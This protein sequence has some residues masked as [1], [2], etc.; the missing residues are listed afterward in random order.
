MIIQ[1]Q[2]RFD[3]LE[4]LR[5]LAAW[6]VVLFH[7]PK[8]NAILDVGIINNSYLM[9]DFFFVLSGFVIFYSYGTKITAKEDLFR[10]QF[11]RFARLYPVHILF[12]L[13]FL[14]FE[15]A[16]QFVQT[17]WGIESVN[18]SPFRENNF[19]AFFQQVFLVHALGPTGNSTSF[20]SPAWSI[21]TEFYTYL[22]FGW[23]LIFIKA[24]RALFFVAVSLG[25]LALLGSSWA[26]GFEEILRCW[27]GFFIGCLIAQFIKHIQIQMPK[28]FSFLV[29]VSLLLFL[30]FK[31]DKQ[32]DLWIYLFSA[33]LIAALVLSRKGALSKWLSSPFLV[34]LGALSYSVYMSHAAIIWIVS[35]CLRLVF[36]KPESLMKGQMIPQ[37]GLWETLA[38]TLILCFFVLVVSIFVY[39]WIEKPL[40]EKSRQSVLRS[41]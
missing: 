11:L 15:I 36:R 4:S 22:F 33:L 17:K 16:K 23:S 3:E 28:Y 10:F 34:G 35:Q 27:S 8:W 37:L 41:R 38:A 40:R 5:G 14:F 6:L 20:N 26:V 24:K 29:G 19:S 21:S 39:R 1:N 25:S 30:Q 18:S 9:V 31:P 12:L 13:V 7:I 32:Q 2:T